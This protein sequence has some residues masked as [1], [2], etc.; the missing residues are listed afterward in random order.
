MLLADKYQHIAS[1]VKDPK[2]A[3]EVD[4][5]DE[6]ASRRRQLATA[7]L[8]TRDAIPAEVDGLKGRVFLGS[9]GAAY[10]RE[11]LK[12]FGI[13]HVLAVGK[14][15]EE[16]FE[17]DGIIYLKL[18]VVDQ[19]KE[20]LREQF[21]I[22]FDFINQALDSLSSHRVLVHCFQGK[23]RSVTVVAAYLMRH[24]DLSFLEALETIRRT[25]PNAEPNLGFAAQLRSFDKAERE[26]RT[27]REQ[28]LHL[29]QG[30]PQIE[31]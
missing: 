26:R 17:K 28:E 12:N 24:L 22:A 16:K 6:K 29:R 25:R 4:K 19:P 3:M 11:S 9:V 18:N 27:L 5:K 8:S 31:S 2:S 21:P 23:S 15:L 1:S 13:T 30:H 7:M 14:G 20:D 10:S